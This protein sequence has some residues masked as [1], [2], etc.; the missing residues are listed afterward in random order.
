MTRTISPT[1]AP[2]TLRRIDNMAPWITGEGRLQ[3]PTF[4]HLIYAEEFLA[5]DY[6]LYEASDIMEQHLV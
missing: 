1:V 3:T 5:I 4:W 6:M 2:L